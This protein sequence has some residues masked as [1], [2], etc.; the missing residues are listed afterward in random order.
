MKASL[1]QTS[2]LIRKLFCQ[3]LLGEPTFSDL[4]KLFCRNGGKTCFCCYQAALIVTR[5]M[6]FFTPFLLNPKFILE[7][8]IYTL[9]SSIKKP[10]YFFVKATA[11]PIFTYLKYH[12]NCFKN[13]KQRKKHNSTIYVI[14]DSAL[15]SLVDPMYSCNFLIH[16]S[17]GRLHVW[18]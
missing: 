4:D 11:L 17:K 3:L 9:Q 6:A 12:C 18:G 1:E 15:S 16:N 14:A 5:L 13:N 2:P 10:V 8:L 7:F